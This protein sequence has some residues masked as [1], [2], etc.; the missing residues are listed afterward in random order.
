MCVAECPRCAMEMHEKH[1]RRLDDSRLDARLG[2]SAQREGSMSVEFSAPTR[3]RAAATLVPAQ[4]YGRGFCS[5]VYPS[6]RRPSAWNTCP[7]GTRRAKWY[8]RERDSRWPCARQPQPVHAASRHLFQRPGIHAGELCRRR[9]NAPAGVMSWPTAR[10]ARRDI[11]RHGDALTLRDRLIS[12]TA[13][14]TRKSSTRA[15]RFSAGRRRR[16]MM[17]AMVFHGRLH[18]VAHRARPKS[19]Q[20]QVVP[21]CVDDGAHRLGE[22]R[23]R[24]AS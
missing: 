1:L 2:D 13:P 19:A 10:S 11:W 24:L 8:A 9:R 20:E 23:T 15:V 14:T 5:G 4:P 18:R 22:Y 7:A 12:S 3:R 6:R 16:V 17:P 21:S